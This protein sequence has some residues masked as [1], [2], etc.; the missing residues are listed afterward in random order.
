MR[1]VATYLIKNKTEAQHSHSEGLHHMQQAD[2]EQYMENRC[3]RLASISPCTNRGWEHEEGKAV[4][5]MPLLFYFGKK[6]KYHS[7]FFLYI[8]SNKHFMSPHGISFLLKYIF[9]N[10]QK[11][12]C[13]FRRTHLT[14]RIMI[15]SSLPVRPFRQSALINTGSMPTTKIKC[16]S[17]VMLSDILAKVTIKLFLVWREAGVHVSCDCSVCSDFRRKQCC[18]STLHVINRACAYCQD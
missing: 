7:L 1:A 11:K 10:G 4:A 5:F 16:V 12:R 13:P 6:C 9:E 2:H 8:R 14:L 3:T 15:G 17:A 18:D